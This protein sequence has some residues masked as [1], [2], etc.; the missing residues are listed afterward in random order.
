[1]NNLNLNI[2]KLTNIF[3]HYLKRVDSSQLIKIPDNFKTHH[4]IWVVIISALEVKLNTNFILPILGIFVSH[5][6]VIK[7]E[8]NFRV[9][10]KCVDEEL[11]LLESVPGS[12]MTEELRDIIFNDIKEHVSRTGFIYT[13][14]VLLLRSYV[15]SFLIYF[16]SL[17]ILSFSGWS[18]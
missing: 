7:D 6:V 11:E 5:L 18:I 16:S 1:M 17:G 12:H 14:S 10:Q 13:R 9:L 3:P 15:L 2:D 8:F 4:F